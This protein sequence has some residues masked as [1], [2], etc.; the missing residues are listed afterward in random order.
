M[1]EIEAIKILKD[2]H[3]YGYE[4]NEA[5]LIAIK[6]LKK[7]IPKKPKFATQNYYCID[8]GNLV[9]ND[10]FEWQRFL[11]CD[12]CGAKLDWKMN[13]MNMSIDELIE[14]CKLKS[15]YIKLKEEP[16]VFVEIA[17]KLEGLK[18]IK[19]DGFSEHLL[20]I[21]YTKGYCKCI[22]DFVII[23]TS[24]LTDAIYQRDV[25]SMTNLINDIA[26]ELKA[27]CKNE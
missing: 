16:Q 26:R 3:S 24:R 7:Q 5:C 1:T 17:E 6:A 23:L 22:D 20:N 12:N 14:F 18:T 15:K 25:A 9:G 13:G 10:E 21:G 8:C 19:S 11:Y 2:E 27:G 4:L